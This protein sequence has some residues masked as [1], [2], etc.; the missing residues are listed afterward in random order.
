MT[1]VTN[2]TSGLLSSVTSGLVFMVDQGVVVPE[3]NTTITSPSS[4]LQTIPDFSATEGTVMLSFTDNAI[5]TTNNGVYMTISAGTGTANRMFLQNRTTGAAMRT[6]TSSGG[7]AKTW[8]SFVSQYPSGFHKVIFAWDASGLS[9]YWD[10]ILE[11]Y[12]LSANSHWTLPVGMDSVYINQL[13]SGGSARGATYSEL[14]Y[15]NT[16]LTDAQCKKASMNNSILT[17]VTKDT[18]KYGVIGL[19]QSNMVGYA[20]GTPVYANALKMFQLTNAIVLGAYADP[21]DL[22]TGAKVPALNDTVTAGNNVGYMGY[23]AN[24][25]VTATGN[26]ICVVPACLG[27]TSFAGSTPSWN[28]SSSAYG[29]GVGMLATGFSA[30]MQAK[31][32]SQY[33]NLNAV[34]FGQ[35]EGDATTA[36]AVPQATYEA[37]YSAYIDIFRAA[38]DMPNLKWIDASLPNYQESATIQAAKEAVGAVKTNMVVL[39][40]TDLAASPHW[41]LTQV[42]TVGGRVAAVL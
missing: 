18:S 22:S 25:Y 38:L 31:L 8:D 37:Q 17:G 42:A 6:A 40:N 14:K 10:G 23:A 12:S 24:D 41:D 13:N 16:K 1:L 39:D 3:A 2:L 35:G 26:D 30:I 29:Q 34:V 20:V 4:G 28:V 27:G 5:Q 7:T 11:H 33:I 19:G 9:V 21:W 15:W 32:A 36:A